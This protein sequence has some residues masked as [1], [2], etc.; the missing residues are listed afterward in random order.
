M[1]S[2]IEELESSVSNYASTA[3]E[4]APEPELAAIRSNYDVV[5]S[6]QKLKQGSIT[7][8]EAKKFYHFLKTRKHNLI[9]YELTISELKRVITDALGRIND[10]AIRTWLVE[11]ESLL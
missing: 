2:K 1:A 8:L 3:E 7:S 10:P 4:V 9:N 5:E 11:A 6:F